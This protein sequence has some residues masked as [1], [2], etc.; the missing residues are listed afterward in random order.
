M[1]FRL[2]MLA[3]GLILGTLMLAMPSTQS[4]A[5]AD[6]KADA[7][8]EL[9]MRAWIGTWAGV[10]EIHDTDKVKLNVPMQLEIAPIPAESAWSWKLTYGM[11][12]K[13]QVR[14]YRLKRT[15]DGELV[16]D[17]QNGILLR[18]DRF[19]PQLITEFE[20]A[21]SCIQTRYRLTDAGIRFELTSTERAK[22]LTSG[23]EKG[24]KV[25]SFRV[26]GYQSAMLQKI[27]PKAKPTPK[28]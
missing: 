12:E 8:L 7:K 23:P 11:G 17:E 18:V 20:I 26:V 4:R 15:A 6:E 25:E 14:D 27:R 1:I 24:P 9:L 2:R 3:V 10:L 22:P 21:G 5:I 16:I 13:K 19:G 28:P